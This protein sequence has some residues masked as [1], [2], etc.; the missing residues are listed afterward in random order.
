MTNING[1]PFADLSIQWRQIRANALP[2]LEKLFDSSAYCLGPWVDAFEKAAAVYLGVRHAVAVNSGSSALHLATI[3][4]GIG[5]GDK[6]MVPAQTFI[7]TIWGVLYQGGIPILCD[8]DAETAT[9]SVEELERRYERGVKAIIPVHL[10]G[11]PANM[12][13]ILQF[14]ERHS[15]TVI[16]DVAQ[17]FGGTY[18]GRK[19]GSLS[20]MGCTSFYPGKNLG[21]AGEGGLIT[22]NDDQTA[23]RLRAL[24][25][26]GQSRRYV[27]DEIGYNYRM[28]G[29]QGLVLGHKL[30]LLDGWTNERRALAARYAKELSGLPLTLPQTLNGDHVWHLYV[31][32]TP[33]RDKLRDHMAAQNVETGLHYPVPL[34]EQPCL[35]AFGFDRN[36]YPNATQWANI[37]LSLPLFVGMTEEQ[38]SRVIAAIKSFFL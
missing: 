29:V 8:V 35:A 27:H 9:I 11:Q 22:T 31:V 25:S 18:G 26:H 28:E 14:A 2:D 32:R 38:Q 12:A 19:L 5:R 3:A 16:E 36:A 20:T 10:F 15:L 17:A 23:T 6:V 24:R 33:Q 13:A 4:S 7:G 1:V 34:H 30:P 37:G 21:A